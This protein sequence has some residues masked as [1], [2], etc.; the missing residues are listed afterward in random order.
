[1]TGAAACALGSIPATS[2]VILLS[3]ALQLQA[4]IKPR[5]WLC[6]IAPLL[7]Q[8]VR[9]WHHWLC[10]QFDGDGDDLVVGMVEE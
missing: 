4:K 2:F 7:Q 9:R 8:Q 10:Q 1:L 5:G 6:R 3:H